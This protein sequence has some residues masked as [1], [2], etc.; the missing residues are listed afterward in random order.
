MVGTLRIY[1]TYWLPQHPQML[2]PSYAR[3]ACSNI[4]HNWHQSK[5][6]AI[7]TKKNINYVILGCF[8]HF[9]LIL[10]PF[11][12]CWII[13][14]ETEVKKNLF[15]GKRPCP[16]WTSCIFNPPSGGLGFW[17]DWL[18]C[19]S[20]GFRKKKLMALHEIFARGGSRAKAQS[21]RF[22]GWSGLRF[23][24]RLQS[25]FR[26]RITIKIISGAHGFSYNF[27][28]RCVSAH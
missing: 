12:S 3:L 21:V 4:F 18:V 7:F 6:A 20:I 23:R 24:S 2:F 17:S 11:W 27:Y 28:Q 9:C 16:M 15:K 22:W 10:K 19:V 26:I 14:K 8:L 1:S 5:M 13:L 25:R